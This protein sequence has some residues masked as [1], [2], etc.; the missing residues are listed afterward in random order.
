MKK[1][2][3]LILLSFFYNS[4]IWASVGLADRPVKEYGLGFFGWILLLFII[5]IIVFIQLIR[6][7][8]LLN[9][10]EMKSVIRII[11][12]NFIYITSILVIAYVFPIANKAIKGDY[13]IYNQEQLNELG[14]KNKEIIRG[15]LL[16]SG[17]KDLTPLK[18]L[19]KIKGDLI[20]SFKDNGYTHQNNEL[21]TLNG[22]NNLKSI[23][24]DLSVKYT[25]LLN[26]K[27]LDNLSKLKGEI[28]IRGNERLKTLIGLEQLKNVN[29]VSISYNMS[30]KSLKGID[31]LTS[32]KNLYILSNDL[33]FS[34]NQL[35]NLESINR[36]YICRN[37]A[38]KS[39]N[40]LINL[41]EV[42]GDLSISKN[43][44]LQ[45]LYGLN[46]II[47]IGGDLRIIQNANI[48][49]LNGLINLRV[50]HGNLEIGTYKPLTNSK[51]ERESDF[52][53]KNLSNFCALKNTEVLGEVYIKNNLF[54]PNFE[55]I[56]SNCS[57]ENLT[58]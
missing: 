12:V 56:S 28:K 40:G 13:I 15:D 31:N 50:I 57:N 52:G 7:A 6:I 55:D 19:Q 27:G 53:N 32:L 46:N 11:K 39:I 30:L 29:G 34:L 33:L 26:L 8:F 47:K 23:G 10:K 37:S 3:L 44:N 16:I 17:V 58:L 2:I 48:T 5:A 54:N 9:H 38:L 4:I 25:S 49:N 42:R 45:S 20:F 21:N 36:I 24:G 51:K 41:K 18:R 14:S 1:I 22:L 35:T 43:Q